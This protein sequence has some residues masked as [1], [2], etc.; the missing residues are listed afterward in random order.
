MGEA[1]EKVT[2]SARCAKAFSEWACCSFQV[3][4]R[5]GL[6][7]APEAEGGGERMGKRI[8]RYLWGV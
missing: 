1:F 4:G 6:D 5:R 3:A 2:W 7:P 8:P